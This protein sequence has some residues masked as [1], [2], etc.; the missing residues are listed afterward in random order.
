[1]P[2]ASRRVKVVSVNVQLLHLIN[3]FGSLKAG[4]NYLQINDKEVDII[5]ILFYCEALNKFYFKHLLF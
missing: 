1:M 5:S 2:H 4:Q 3:M